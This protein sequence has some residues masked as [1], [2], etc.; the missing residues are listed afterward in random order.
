M[1]GIQLELAQSTY[2]ASEAPPFFYDADKASG[3]RGTIQ[4]LLAR[5][6]AV[7]LGLK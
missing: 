7:A 6:E 2:L 5:I 3:L 4:T 1:H